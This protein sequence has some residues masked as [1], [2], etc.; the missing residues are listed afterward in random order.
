MSATPERRAGSRESAALSWL[1]R[2]QART[3][4]IGDGLLI[5][6]AHADDEVIGIGGQLDRLAGVSLVHITDGAPRNLRDARTAGFDRWESYAAARREELLAALSLADIDATR[7]DQLDIPDQE[8]SFRLVE[9]ARTMAAKLDARRPEIVLTHAYEGGHPDHDAAAF[10]VHAACALVKR[11]GG[12]APAIVEMTG[13]HMGQ[14]APVKS[15]FLEDPGTPATTLV[16]G[17]RE[18]ALKRRL[19]NCFATQSRVLAGFRLDVERFRP[20][21]DYDFTQPPHE[22]RMFYEHFDWGIDGVGWRALA[23]NALA[24]LEIAGRS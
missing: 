3:G 7:A 14:G 15:E 24:A 22:G 5:V 19:V 2:L 18:R 6:A 21:P 11:C 4:S 9:L 13:Y 23:G 16:L 1:R 8:T 17:E 20:A 12:P 10:A